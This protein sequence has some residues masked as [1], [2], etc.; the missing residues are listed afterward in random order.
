MHPPN[1][2]MWM[3]VYLLSDCVLFGRSGVVK[4]GGEMG[5]VTGCRSC[6]EKK[7]SY[8][9]EGARERWGGVIECGWG[10]SLS[11]EFVYLSRLVGCPPW[12]ASR[13]LNSTSLRISLYNT[14]TTS[15]MHH[16]SEWFSPVCMYVY[17]SRV[18]PRLYGVCVRAVCSRV[19]AGRY[20]IP[21]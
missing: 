20:G 19:V 9:I 21:Q 6:V 5:S 18:L 4:S 14:H 17:Q 2:W 16:I 13:N 10:Y 8:N 11:P 1:V 3:C 15:S 12:L 7:R